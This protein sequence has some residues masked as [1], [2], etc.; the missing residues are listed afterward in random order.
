MGTVLRDVIV[1]F[2]LF[3]AYIP[4]CNWRCFLFFFVFISQGVFHHSWKVGQF[5][6]AGS[7]WTDHKSQVLPQKLGGT[8]DAFHY[9]SEVGF[10]SFAAS[11]LIAPLGFRILE[12]WRKLELGIQYDRHVY[13]QC[14]DK[15]SSVN[16]ALTSCSHTLHE[17]LRCKQFIFTCSTLV[18]TWM[19]QCPPLAISSCSLLLWAREE[20]ELLLPSNSHVAEPKEKCEF[21]TA[22]SCPSVRTKK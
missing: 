19:R 5:P 13:Q 7:K 10:S 9:N 17:A 3:P 21:Q 8:S 12:S 18:P 22:K 15:H 20:K 2:T 14:F 1:L 6:P 11:Y 4:F 16:S